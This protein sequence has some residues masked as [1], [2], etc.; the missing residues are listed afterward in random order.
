MYNTTEDLTAPVACTAET[1]VGGDADNE[2]KV[3]QLI[4]LGFTREMAEEAL[5]ACG[6]SIDHAASLLFSQ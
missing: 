1:Y 5:K 4:G 3:T 6:G 2:T